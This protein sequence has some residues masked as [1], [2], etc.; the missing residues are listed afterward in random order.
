M[1]FSKTK[2]FPRYTL[3]MEPI[4]PYFIPTYFKCI[5]RVEKQ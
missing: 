1:L 2:Y 3:N 5:K 4:F